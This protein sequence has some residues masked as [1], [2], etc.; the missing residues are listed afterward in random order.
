MRKSFSFQAIEETRHSPVLQPE[1][2]G[3]VVPSVSNH[4]LPQWKWLK[5]TYVGPEAKFYVAHA[6][7][8][9]QIGLVSPE[10]F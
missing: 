9:L 10:K 5:V 2:K 8:C 7:R 1:F 3:P 4:I 6:S